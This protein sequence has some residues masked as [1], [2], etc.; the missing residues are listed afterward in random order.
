[1]TH[2]T[3]VLPQSIVLAVGL[4]AAAAAQAQSSAAAPAPQRGGTLVLP[5]HV[6]EP[7]TYDCH[8]TNSPAAMWRVS[9]HYSTL[10]KIDAD[11]FPQ[12]SGD[13]A[14][15]WTESPDRLTWRFTLQPNIKFHDG[16]ALT[17]A[18]VKASFDRLRNPPPGVVSLRQ[19]MLADIADIETPDDATVV[20]KFKRRHAAAL[21]LL[22]MPYA[23][24]YSARLMASDPAYPAKR[25]MG[26]GPFKFVR[27]TP[28]SEWVG[29]RFAD[30]FLA[31]KPYL[32]GIRLL[33]VAPVA[34]TNALLAGQVHFTMQGLTPPE[35]ARITA[36]RGDKVKVVGGGKA[37][38][39][40]P[41]FAINTQRDAVKDERVRRA[42]NL[43]LDRWG[44]SRAME[45]ITPMFRVG[46]LVRPGATFAR[47]DDELA[48]LPG[49]GRDIEAARAEARKLLSAAGK[50][51]LKLTVV[52]N[53]A[54]TYFGVYVADQLSKIGVQV[55]H[56][57][58][59]TPQV[60]ARRTSGDYDLIFD[61]TAEFVDDPSIQLAYFEPFSTNRANLARV[62][63]PTF[64]EMFQA[65]LQDVNP[66]TRAK[67]VREL[68]AYLMQ[69][70][71]VMPL[72]WQS[73]KRVI[74]AGL[75]GLDGDYPS[76]YVKLDF[77]DLWL[78]AAARK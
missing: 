29:E 38:T 21:Q 47:S 13:L 49:F 62:G 35:V 25:V 18:D 40:G 14:K 64:V 50:S 57:P 27:Y 19:G 2:P 52:N 3:F 10:L 23:C 26:S 74:D 36:A 20:F 5:I 73:R 55:E 65:Q 28:G 15:S 31:G 63:D 72:F 46:A 12:V 70:S 78:D 56:L 33:S 69:K 4:L 16:S 39:F 7:P 24:I 58:L 30:Y 54:F 22:A 61:S 6:G 9:P 76:N 77:S 48:K 68:E 75:H 32:D 8:A 66:T 11:R 42:L 53:R 71:Y 34:A 44:A 37:T 1:M 67:K 60:A 45:Q 59:D 41:W 43:A 17:S 51:N